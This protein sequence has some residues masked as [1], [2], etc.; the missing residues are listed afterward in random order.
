MSRIWLIREASWL[1]GGVKANVDSSNHLLSFRLGLFNSIFD[2]GSNPRAY[3]Q[4]QIAVWTFTYQLLGLLSYAKHSGFKYTSELEPL[5]SHFLPSHPV[6]TLSSWTILALEISCVSVE[7]ASS[8]REQLVSTPPQN[9]I[10]ILNTSL[11]GKSSL[12]VQFV[13]NHFV[14]PYYPTIESTHFKTIPHNGVNY[15]VSI[16]DTAG[17]DE[18]SLLSPKLAVGM[19]GYVLV[20]SV[21]NRQSFEMVRIV[22]DKLKNFQVI[23]SL[24]PFLFH[25]LIPILLSISS[26]CQPS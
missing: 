4:L 15:D 2:F 23:I 18:Y 10:A 21:T 13:E 9:R 20:Y 26:I 19:H 7:F 22:Y 6:I 1:T 17:Q 16:T 5:N 11:I 24:F 12:I 25:L 8:A 14:E 3:N